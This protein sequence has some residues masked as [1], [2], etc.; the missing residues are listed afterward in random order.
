VS[1]KTGIA[2][3][4]RITRERRVFVGRVGGVEPEHV[5]GIVV[6]D[7]ERENHATVQGAAHALHAAF[8]CEVVVVLDLCQWTEYW[9]ELPV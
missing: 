8:G 4:R 7:R 9:R 6:P 5:R 3:K 1:T 2:Y